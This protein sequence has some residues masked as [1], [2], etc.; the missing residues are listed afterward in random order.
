MAEHATPDDSGNNGEGDD[1]DD[2]GHDDHGHESDAL[3]P[4]DTERWRAFGLGIG[5]GLIV[6]LCIVVATR[7]PS[8]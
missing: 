1:G 8:A 7:G 6:A 3:G 5:L 2:H 4:V